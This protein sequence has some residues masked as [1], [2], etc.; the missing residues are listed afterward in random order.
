MSSISVTNVT[1]DS[2]RS[3]DVHLGNKATHTTLSVR[4][5]AKLVEGVD[6]NFGC[7]LSFVAN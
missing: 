3:E 4:L 6:V 1:W 5:V 7:V 2:F